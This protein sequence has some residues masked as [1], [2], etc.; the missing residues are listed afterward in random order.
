M[1]VI[2]KA[3]YI[4]LLLME[5]LQNVSIFELDLGIFRTLTF[6]YG[7]FKY[8]PKYT[9]PKSTKVYVCDL[10]GFITR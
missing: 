7:F 8:T 10:K 4:I 3:K 5:I 9:A 1:Y 2:K 6:L